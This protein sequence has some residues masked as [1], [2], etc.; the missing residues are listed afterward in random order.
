M[1]NQRDRSIQTPDTLNRAERPKTQ[2]TDYEIRGNE[3][4]VRSEGKEKCLMKFGNA[5]DAEDFLRH[6]KRRPVEFFL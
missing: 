2:S 4:W 6:F 5:L 3:I 1:F